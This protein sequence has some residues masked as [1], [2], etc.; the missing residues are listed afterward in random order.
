M[1]WFAAA[2]G[3]ENLAAHFPFPAP[4][5]LKTTAAYIRHKPDIGV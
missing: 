1:P 5:S 3:F 4:M 2:D